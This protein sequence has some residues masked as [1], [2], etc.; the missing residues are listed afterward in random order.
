MQTVRTRLSF[1][2]DETILVSH[3]LSLYCS[4]IFGGQ[5]LS[6]SGSGFG[7]NPNQLDI[8]LGGRPCEVVSVA[9]DEIL[10]VTSPATHTHQVNN[11]A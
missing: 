10:C 4:S 7:D 2:L 8:A 3:V 11:N 5:V 9:D 1:F 6:F